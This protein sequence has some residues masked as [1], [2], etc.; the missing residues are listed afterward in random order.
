MENVCHLLA[1]LEKLT[2]DFSAYDARLS[3]VIPGIL[4]LKL[5]LQADK[6]D[7]G[8]KTMKSGLLGALDERFEPLLANTCATIATAVDPHFKL[9]FF[10]SDTVR[11]EVKQAVRDAALVA[12]Q[13]QREAAVEQQQPTVR[14]QHATATDHETETPSASTSSSNAQG[15]YFGFTSVTKK[16]TTT[17]TQ[18]YTTN[19]VYNSKHT[20]IL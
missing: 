4:G 3:A 19:L 12:S 10:P 9:R 6:R 11:D 20:L 8:V 5:T 15:T 17:T 16:S 14:S 7:V 1:P 2:R 13:Q 18:Y